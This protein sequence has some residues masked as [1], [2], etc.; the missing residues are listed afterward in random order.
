MLD[1]LR[2]GASLSILFL[3]ILIAAQI[4]Q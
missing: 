4:G 2:E 3:F 1:N